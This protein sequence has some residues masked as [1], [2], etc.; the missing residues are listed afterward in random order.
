MMDSSR[1]S[2]LSF[3]QQ[4]GHVG[5]EI[6]RVRHW[7]KQK[8]TA[9]RTQALERAL[10]LLDLTLDST[11]TVSQLKEIAR[12]REVVAVWYLGQKTYDINEA[13]LENYCVSFSMMH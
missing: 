2:E 5:S 11:K 12:L 10:E 13:G 1:W 8:D 3:A 4:M 6:A 9:S 7:E